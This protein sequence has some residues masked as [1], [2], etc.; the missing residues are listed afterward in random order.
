[1][2]KTRMLVGIALMVQVVFLSLIL[3]AAAAP[4]AAI[5]TGLERLQTKV[6]GEAATISTT[7][8]GNRRIQTAGDSFLMTDSGH[9]VV[10]TI[11]ICSTLASIAVLVLFLFS[12]RN[13][14]EA[15]ATC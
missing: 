14:S 12:L 1:M 7:T 15:P 6:P 3:I 13:K 10:T 4:P 2:N 9:G 8:H 11:S 5:R